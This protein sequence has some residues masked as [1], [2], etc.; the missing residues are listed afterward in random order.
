M[1]FV[2]K[3]ARLAGQET[4]QSRAAAA[5]LEF[6]ADLEAERE[7]QGVSYYELAALCGMS[8]TSL[9]GV[10]R[11]EQRAGLARILAIADVLGCSFV[12]KCSR[13]RGG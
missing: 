1:P 5:A 4:V 10:L 8:Q 3:R 11:G 7:R 9:T 6:Q 13:K 2:N 12:L